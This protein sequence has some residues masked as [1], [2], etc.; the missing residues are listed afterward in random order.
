MSTVMDF[1]SKWFGQE[2]E[3]LAQVRYNRCQDGGCTPEEASV[4]PSVDVT[5][6]DFWTDD[7]DPM[8]PLNPPF[9]EMAYSYL[10]ASGEIFDNTV[11]PAAGSPP[12]T[13]DCI[14]AW[15]KSCRIVINYEDHIH[16]IWSKSRLDASNNDATCTTCHNTLDINGQ[17]QVP[18]GQLN[19]SENFL[20][21]PTFTDNGQ[22][23]A[24]QELFF[25]D[26]ELVM[27]AAMNGLEERLVP[28]P[29]FDTDG[30]PI[31]IDVPV[32]VVPSMTANGA[33]RSYFFE[34]L[35]NTQLEAPG[36]PA[37]G[38]DHTLF[39]TPAEK[40]IIAEWLDIGAQYY[41][42]PSDVPQN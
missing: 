31:T 16:P 7:A 38:L 6:Q 33:R 39:L 28:Q 22:M 18:A 3:T 10:Q 5:Y 19:L 4:T 20:Q 21:D 15:D 35:T 17:V 12:T 29:S 34:K 2:S 9:D 42:D 41:N 14:A 13:V 27:N 26:T 32:N 11:M 8:N 37:G 23:P 25:T 24:Y 40:R 1:K 30:N 36:D